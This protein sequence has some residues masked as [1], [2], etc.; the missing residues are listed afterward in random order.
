MYTIMKP[1][2]QTINS[3]GTVRLKGYEPIYESDNLEKVRIE[4]NKHYGTCIQYGKKAIRTEQTIR[5]TES[6]K[7]IKPSV[8]LY[9]NGDSIPD[10]RRLEKS[11][12]G[13]F[14]VIA[15]NEKVYP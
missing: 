11:K 8:S 4:M 10:H 14:Y 1:I 7:T 15:K 5:N 6:R 12:R 2:Y 3:K 9:Y 13:T